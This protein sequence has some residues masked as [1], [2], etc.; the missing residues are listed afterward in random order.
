M[1]KDNKYLSGD[2]SSEELS[3]PFDD[4][5]DLEDFFIEGNDNS[6]NQTLLDDDYKICIDEASQTISADDYNEES[7]SNNPEHNRTY[8]CDKNNKFDFRDYCFLFLFAWLFIGLIC[9]LVNIGIESISNLLFIGFA[10]PTFLAIYFVILPNLYL[11]ILASFFFLS[12]MPTYT[13]DVMHIRS[14]S[15]CSGFAL[16]IVIFIY[17]SDMCSY[18]HIFQER[19]P[20]NPLYA[21]K[22]IRTE[23]IFCCKDFFDNLYSRQKVSPGTF[24]D[25]VLYKH[26][27]LYQKALNNIMREVLN[28]DYFGIHALDELNIQQK[29]VILA[30]AKSINT[31]GVSDK[32]LLTML[33]QYFLYHDTPFSNWATIAVVK[34]S[35]NAN[36]AW[37]HVLSVYRNLDVQQ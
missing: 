16:F 27:P 37:Q 9:W 17:L 8:Y 15:V 33:H 19:L 4:L 21:Y 12:V 20:F 26:L 34:Y 28:N 10:F 25:M 1:N 6:L 11:F 31:L 22:K 18:Q 36:V 14:M 30:K 29:K 32:Y 5:E 24:Y 2:N 23:L 7:T 3:N 13:Q 35:N